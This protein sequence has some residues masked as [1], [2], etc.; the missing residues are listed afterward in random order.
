MIFFYGITG[1]RIDV[2]FFCMTSALQ[3]T[4]RGK[5][6]YPLAT[7][8]R[9]ARSLGRF[10]SLLGTFAVTVYGFC[11]A[12]RRLLPLLVESI[13]NFERRC[14]DGGHLA[15]REWPTSGFAAVQTTT[16]RTQ[17][18]PSPYRH[19]ACRLFFAHQQLHWRAFQIDSFRFQGANL[20][21]R[22][23]TVLT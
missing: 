14:H 6:A 7:C 19:G 5:S 12:G 4:A 16:L 21:S 9:R 3:V 22:K 11:A 18:H 23:R 10:K 15:Q 20:K 1:T 2:V 13:S 8:E 17:P